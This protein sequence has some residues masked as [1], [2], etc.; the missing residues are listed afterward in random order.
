MSKSL[1]TLGLMILLTGACAPR[2]QA[3]TATTETS[4]PTATQASVA[5]P[6]DLQFMDTMVAHHE[7][8]I[9]MSE[10]AGQKGGAAVKTMA[11]RIASDQQKEIETLRSWR[12]QWYSGQAGAPN[13]EMPGAS[14]MN[15]DMTHMQSLSGRSFDTMFIDMM[16]PHHEGAITMS[17]DALQRAEH[18]ELRQFAQQVIEKQQKEIEE[19]RRMKTRGAAGP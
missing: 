7:M 4:L 12:D 2:E 13:M 1:A 18:A 11:A 6:Y 19:L 5:Q 8:A 3:E 9:R 14:S 17:Q 10:M 16:I 15:M